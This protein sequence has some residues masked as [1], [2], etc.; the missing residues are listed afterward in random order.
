M[1][2]RTRRILRRLPIV[3]ALLALAWLL[4][5]TRGHEITFVYALPKDPPPTRAEVRLFN[6]DGSVASELSWG[7]GTSPAQP[8]ETQKV[9]LDN[10]SYRLEALLDFAESP[11]RRVD[12][13][14]V[15]TS[16]DERITVYLQ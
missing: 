12:R 13:T 6:G 4:W 1:T 14:I 7:S 15:I 10:G 2:Q 9:R 3:L 5:G 16:E 11:S 8:R